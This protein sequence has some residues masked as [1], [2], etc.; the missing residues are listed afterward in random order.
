MNSE[1]IKRGLDRYYRELRADEGIRAIED[2]S[3]GA[4]ISTIC[5]YLRHIAVNIAEISSHLK[6]LVKK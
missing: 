6:E 5:F 4:D 2:F 1:E 3:E